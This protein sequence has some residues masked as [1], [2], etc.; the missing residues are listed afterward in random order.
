M[1][2]SYAVCTSALV[3]LLLVLLYQVWNSYRAI[4]AANYFPKSLVLFSIRE[5]EERMED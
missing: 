4:G 3:T 2:E 1:Y 5:A